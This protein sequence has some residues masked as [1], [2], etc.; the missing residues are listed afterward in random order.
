MGKLVLLCLIQPRFP[1]AARPWGAY[2]Q[3]GPPSARH[4]LGARWRRATS[5]LVVAA[6]PRGRAGGSRT[7][8]GSAQ[9]LQAPAPQLSACAAGSLRLGA[10]QAPSDPQG[11]HRKMQEHWARVGAVGLQ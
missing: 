10:S 3:R 5:A 2:G 9:T 8:V 11:M 4:P 7:R 6:R 1:I